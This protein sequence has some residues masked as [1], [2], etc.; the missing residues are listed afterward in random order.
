MHYKGQLYLRCEILQYPFHYN[1][2]TTHLEGYYIVSGSV[3]RTLALETNVVVIS[4][5]FC[6]VYCVMNRM[7][8]TCLRLLMKERDKSQPT[9]R[10]YL[11]IW[12]E[13]LIKTL[14]EHSYDSRNANWVQESVQKYFENKH[15]GETSGPIL[16]Y[17]P[18]KLC[19]HILH[20]CTR[21]TSF[22]YSMWSK[23]IYIQNNWIQ[24]L[25]TSTQSH[26]L[27]FLCTTE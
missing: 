25:L 26:F 27:R 5:S 17:S 14:R 24:I 8:T 22:Y 7:N 13:E 2:T 6:K 3:T 16:F 19:L 4:Y 23:F 21:A 10:C 11:S 20:N 18:T 9:G 12:L 1:F 15:F